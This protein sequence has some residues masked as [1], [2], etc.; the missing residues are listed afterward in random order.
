MKKYILL[1]LLLSPLYIQAQSEQEIGSIT[2]HC[3]DSRM[4]NLSSHYTADGVGFDLGYSR[5]NKNASITNLNLEYDKGNYATKNQYNI[6][7]AN[8]C[9]SKPIIK[10]QRF[11][12][13]I[14]GGTFVSYEK[15]ENSI[16]HLS[17]NQFSPGALV[18]MEAELFL[19]RYALYSSFEQLY[20][21]NSIIGNW[22][23]QVSVG[24]KYIL[25]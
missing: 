6:V 25:K 8:L 11:Y 17:K 24:I 2:P 4:I 3:Y 15:I 23:Y 20:R 10:R 7:S 16:L 9:L 1:I 14:G 19:S 13:S 22:Q 18:K 12:A 21:T 5:I